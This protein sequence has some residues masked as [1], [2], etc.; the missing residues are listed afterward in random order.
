[1]KHPSHKRS[2][3]DWYFP[4]VNGQVM[5]PKRPTDKERSL[6]LFLK[7]GLPMRRH[8]RL[9]AVL[10]FATVWGLG[11]AY[12]EVSASLSSE[13]KAASRA[14]AVKKTAEKV[15]PK[16]AKKTEQTVTGTV[17]YVGKRQISIETMQSEEAGVEE[18]MIPIRE[19][20]KIS[21]AETLK[22]IAYGDQV[23][24]RFAQIYMPG[25]KPGQVAAV[26]DTHALEVR[27]LQKA[28]DM[29]AAA[30]AAAVGGG[31]AS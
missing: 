18:I 15:Y 30:T 12:A 3:M 4:R 8:G 6:Y 17:G 14:A 2:H 26:L 7:K 19:G 27:L 16:E 5:L 20:L 28:A 13:R 31:G 9:A 11:V 25:K 23:E 24:V 22:D 10:A 21:N 29:A 1:M